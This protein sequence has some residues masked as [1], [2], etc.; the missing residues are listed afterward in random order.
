MPATALTV[1]SN[2]GTIPAL[3]PTHQPADVSWWLEPMTR[4]EFMARAELESIRMQ[5]SKGAAWVD[6]MR[7]VSAAE[8]M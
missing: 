2:F 3:I 5:G 6:H 4:A 8:W 7:V 1:T